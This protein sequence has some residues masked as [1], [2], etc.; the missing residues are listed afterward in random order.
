MFTNRLITPVLGILLAM[1]MVIITGLA[2]TN[3]QL[4]Q[5]L[6]EANSTITKQ[7]Q[8][9]A[10]LGTA[11]SIQNQAVDG[12]VEEA[13]KAIEQSEKAL[14]DLQPF[15]EEEERRILGIRSAQHSSL[16]NDASERL[17]NIR[18]KMLQDALL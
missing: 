16:S 1:A 18:Q 2:I 3:W 7:A 8:N 13:D 5:Q 12:L 15:V 11:V 10:V 6:T 9:V 17:E 14:A 4:D